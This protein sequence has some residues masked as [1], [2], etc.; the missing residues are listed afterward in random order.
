MLPPLQP[1][2]ISTS[3]FSRRK[4]L[5]RPREAAHFTLPEPMTSATRL[6]SSLFSAMVFLLRIASRG[7]RHVAEHLE[8]AREAGEIEDALHIRRHAGEAEIAAFP[9]RLF[10]R[11]Q[12]RAQARAARVIHAGEIGDQSRLARAELLLHRREQR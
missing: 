9:A 5:R 7:G 2:T 10:H 4:T 11:R 1:T 8:N 12:Q 6:R 3:M